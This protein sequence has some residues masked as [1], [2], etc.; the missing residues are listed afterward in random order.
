[1]TRGLALLMFTSIRANFWLRMV[2]LDQILHVLDRVALCRC[3]SW[4]VERC[5]FPPPCSCE[6]NPIAF[7]SSPPWSVIPVQRTHHRCVDCKFSPFLSPAKATRPPRLPTFCHLAHKVVEGPCIGPSR[8]FRNMQDL[9]SD[10]KT[11]CER[12]FRILQ[13]RLEQSSNV[14]LSSTKDQSKLHQSGEKFRQV[15]FSVMYC[16]RV[17]L[18]WR[19]SMIADIE[20]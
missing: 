12:R 17:N 19:D 15:Y 5:L 18:E 1:M 6:C 4:V 9:L 16:T 8:Y 20:E 3:N 11:P 13:Y 10:G 2:R 14:T 7:S